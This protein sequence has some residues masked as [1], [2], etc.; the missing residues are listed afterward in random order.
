M[1]D[2]IT[3]ISPAI[4]TYTHYLI[5]LFTTIYKSRP[6]PFDNPGPTVISTNLNTSNPHLYKLQHQS[7]FHSITIN[8]SH[9]TYKSFSFS[10]KTTI[11]FSTPAS[12]SSIRVPRLPCSELGVLVRVS[13][14]RHYSIRHAALWGF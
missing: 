7:Y 4:I 13:W 1:L 9:S 6:P 11:L 14:N 5:H 2:I 8:S 12:T 3:T 10:A